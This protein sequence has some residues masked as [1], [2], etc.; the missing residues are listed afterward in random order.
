MTAPKFNTALLF[1]L[2]IPCVAF[3]QS[4]EN[5]CVTSVD[6][7]TVVVENTVTYPDGTNFEEGDTLSVYSD[8]GTCAGY[9]AWTGDESVAIA[10]AGKDPITGQGGY[11]EGELIK[12]EAY[13]VSEDQVVDIGA[14]V[15]Y[16]CDNG[17]SICSESGKYSDGLIFNVTKFGGS[18]IPVELAQF[19]VSN[20]GSSATL[21]WVTASEQNNVGFRVQHKGPSGTVFEDVG[22]VEGQRTSSKPREYTYSVRNLDVGTHQFR[23]KQVDQDGS[24]YLSD[25]VS[26]VLE[27]G[28]ELFEPRPHPATD[29]TK[30]LFTV[31]ET[32]SVEISLYNVLG[33]RVKTVYSST[34]QKNEKH[35]VNIN[36]SD[37]SSGTYFISLEAGG[38]RKSQ[39]LVV[40]K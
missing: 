38:D 36:T 26:I 1:I 37:L 10:A 39:K 20:S 12:Y 13:D 4:Y 17:L 30:V 31:H 35:A 7:A 18:P 32:Q 16:S 8:D 22:F 11:E 25:P 15:R 28:L 23:L 33:Q 19:S 3:S 24:T 34:A 2:L 14:R 9:A 5:D 29:Y 27:S 6:N 21:R 40:T